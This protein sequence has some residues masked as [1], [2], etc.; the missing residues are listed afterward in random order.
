MN[1]L[2]TVQGEKNTEAKRDLIVKE[3]NV[4]LRI[5]PKSLRIHD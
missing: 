5:A 3:K 1:G 4:W 2:E